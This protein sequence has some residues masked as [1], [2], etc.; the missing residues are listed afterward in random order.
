MIPRRPGRRRDGNRTARAAHVEGFPA[1]RSRAGLPAGLR[2]ALARGRDAPHLVAR[3]PELPRD[4]ARL[5]PGLQR[6]PDHPL[7]ARPERRRLASTRPRRRA[8]V[9]TARSSFTRQ[10]PQYALANRLGTDAIPAGDLAVRLSRLPPCHHLIGAFPGPVAP[11]PHRPGREETNRFPHLAGRHAEPRGERFRF[12]TLPVGLDHLP[13]FGAREQG[14]TAARPHRF[15]SNAT[16]RSCHR[17][18]GHAE[19]GCNLSKRKPLPVRFDQLPFHLV[20]LPAVRHR[21]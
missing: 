20:A 21:P 11:W 10:S 19:P 12:G 14:A 16:N 1:V 4:G 18:A 15:G 9:P 3:E 17:A 8:S 2:R 7:K 6:R 13:F 5:D